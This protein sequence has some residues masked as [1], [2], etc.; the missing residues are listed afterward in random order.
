[1]PPILNSVLPISGWIRGYRREDFRG[2]L[3]AGI[4]VGVMLIPQ[5]MA[6]ALLA[7]VPPVYGMYASLVPL[8]V[9]PLFTSS[10]HLAVGIMAL[11]CMIVAA[12]LGNLAEPFSS[13]YIGLAIILTLMVGLLQLTM[14]LLRFGFVVNLLS[15]PVIQGFTAAAALTIA[16]SQIRNLTGISEMHSANVMQILSDMIRLGGDSHIPTLL[17]GLG[18]IVLLVGIRRV[19]PR[20]PGPLMAVIIGTVLVWTARMDISGV[21]IV[22]SIPA[23]LPAF[24]VPGITFESVQALIPTA[25]TLALLQFVTVI[26]LSKVFAMRHRYGIEAN[27][28]MVALGAMNL[29]GSLFRSLPVSGSFSRSAVTDQSGGRSSLA[30]FVAALVIGLTL[31]VLTPLFYYLPIPVFASIIIVSAM[32]LVDVRELR[33]LLKTK[34]IDGLLS[35]A[36]FLATLF[37]GIHQGILT[38]VGLS[39]LAMLYQV[40]RPRV[41]IL[42]KIPGKNMFRD[43]AHHPEARQ[44]EGIFIIRLDERLGFAN[45]EYVR[46]FIFSHLRSDPAGVLILDACSINDLDTTALLVLQ[47]IHDVLSE[48]GVKFQVTGA[49][50]T[51]Y[52]VLRE[53]GLYDRIGPSHFF[54]SVGDAISKTPVPPGGIPSL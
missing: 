51:V 21:A 43:M 13:E 17:I 4:T 9:F 12:G 19:V 23:G 3:I 50:A 47:E 24:S 54:L 10:R 14:G 6:Y 52:N 38:G 32:N 29:A 35:V 31:L 18:G 46:D 16:L 26:S 20:I 30:N 8:A 25:I 27:R 40:S 44:V 36:T 22:G 45:A 48:R 39:L 15:R 28:E 2:D 33:F 49:K 42:G 7:G 1:M 37:V 53:S 5:S 34:R 41:A 11:D